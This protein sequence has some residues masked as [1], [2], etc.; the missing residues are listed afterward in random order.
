MSS[1]RQRGLVIA[2]AVVVVID[3]TAQTAGQS[4][5]PPRPTSR[6]GLYFTEPAVSP[7]CSEVAFA[8]G[9]DIWTVPIAGGEARLLV[10][11]VA[12]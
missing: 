3:A 1:F 11:H 7:D 12:N 8:S 4:R 10:S 5:P 9:G 2:V 6:P